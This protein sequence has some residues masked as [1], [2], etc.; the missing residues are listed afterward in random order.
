MSDPQFPRPDGRAHDRAHDRIAAFLVMDIQR[1]PDWARD[2]LAKIADVKTGARSS[3]ERI[4]NAY[5]L[6]LSTEG[7]L[8]E[9]LVDPTSAPPRIPL[10]ELETAVRAWLE[11]TG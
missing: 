4:G 2:L 3:W 7:A 10:E 6:S 1:S 5:R 9:D 8:I 11:A